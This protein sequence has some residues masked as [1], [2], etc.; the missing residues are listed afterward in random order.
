MNNQEVFHLDIVS[1]L[2]K[3]VQ[4]LAKEKWAK[5][6][7]SPEFFLSLDNDDMNNQKIIIT[8]N[9][10]NRRFSETL[11]PRTDAQYGYDSVLSQMI[12][13]YNRTM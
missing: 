9:H 12:S 5:D 3:E 7:C 2:E 13:L 4:K 1:M 8:I 6:N 10:M 11:F